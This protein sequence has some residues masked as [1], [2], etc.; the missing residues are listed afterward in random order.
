MNSALQVLMSVEQFALYFLRE[1]YR[2]DDRNYLFCDMICE[3][4][5]GMRLSANQGVYH[6]LK[7][8]HK[9]ESKFNST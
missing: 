3:L 5:N 2:Q 9:I 6:N 7:F 8:K 4:I 1:K